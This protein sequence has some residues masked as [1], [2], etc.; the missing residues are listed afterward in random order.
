MNTVGTKRINDPEVRRRQIL[1]EAMKLFYEKGYDNTSLDDI[2]VS[3]D[4]TKGLCYRYFSSKQALLDEVISEY[5][6]ECCADFIPI[7]Q[8]TTL[9]MSERLTH[10]LTLLFHPAKNGSH[11]DFFHKSGN[12]SI[13]R[14]LA[15]TMCTYLVPYAVKALKSE[16]L[17]GND[18]AT[19]VENAPT[20]DTSPQVTAQFLL[21][22]MFGIWQENKSCTSAMLSQFTSMTEQILSVNNGR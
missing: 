10:I 18:I 5:T 1:E 15:S 2:A 4:I 12:E 9:S 6:Q 20:K 8:D 17:A 7:L 19:S 11:H 21:Y 3:L 16:R 22:G 13:H 14:Q